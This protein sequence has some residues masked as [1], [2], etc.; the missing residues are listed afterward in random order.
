MK[1]FMLSLVTC[2]VAMNATLFLKDYL[3]GSPF[4]FNPILSVVTPVLCAVAA[5]GVE[6]YKTRKNG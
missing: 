4:V 5:W 2:F 1:K 3:Y 6:E